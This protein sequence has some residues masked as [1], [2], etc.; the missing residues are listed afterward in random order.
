M[1]AAYLLQP[2]HEIT[3]YE[4][5]PRIGGHTRTLTVV[6]SGTEIPVDTGFIVYNERN[7]PLLTALFQH[8]DVPTHKS[9][10]TFAATIGDG[11]LEWG[12]KNL[13]TVFAQRRNLV[14][15]HFYRLLRDVM[16]FNAVA[17]DTAKKHPRI[18][19]QDLIDRLGLGDWFRRYYLLPMAGAIWSCPPSQMLAFPALAFLRFFE[20]HGLLSASGQPQWRTVTGGAQEY[21][22]RLTHS[23]SSRVR[24]DCGAVEIRRSERG[25]RVRDSRGNEELYDH[26]VFASHADETLALLKDAGNDERAA[27]SAFQY[28]ENR[29]VLHKDSSV[30]PKRKKCWASWVYHANVETSEPA[31]AVS[32]WMNKLQGIDQRFPL[33]VTLNPKRD[34]SKTDVF[35]EHVFHHPVFDTAALDA[36]VHM[37]ALQGQRNTWYCGAYMR[38]GF[39]ED[40]LS[41]AVDVALRLGARPPWDNRSTPIPPR[42]TPLPT[43]A[44]EPTLIR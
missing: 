24:T 44:V 37:K 2:H 35:D 28:Q 31:I 13:D 32:Y 17:L 5:A 3:V 39:H 20:N 8:L 33:F 27:L 7:Y 10:M 42:A 26:V 14:R 21:V 36:Q 40:G 22:R 6:H 18:T 30:M 16:R 29:A 34:F 15:P 4:K 41:S 19:L 9:D 25:V 43:R 23:F 12:A 1:G 11:W 38:N